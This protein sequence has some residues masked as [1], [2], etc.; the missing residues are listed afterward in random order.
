[1]VLLACLQVG[2]PDPLSAAWTWDSRLKEQRDLCKHDPA[3]RAYFA[4]QRGE[5]LGGGMFYTPA[6]GAPAADQEDEPLED[7]EAAEIGG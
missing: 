4:A 5:V 1:M 2:E 7:A 3:A 6:T